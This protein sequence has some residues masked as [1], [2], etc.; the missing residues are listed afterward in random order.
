MATNRQSRGEGRPWSEVAAGATTDA[1]PEA[2]WSAERLSCGEGLV[3]GR[4]RRV[5]PLYYA[6]PGRGGGA[7]CRWQ[8]RR[9]KGKLGANSEEVK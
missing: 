1:S 5:L 2:R 8:R 3:S 9:R 4:G 7:L 6:R